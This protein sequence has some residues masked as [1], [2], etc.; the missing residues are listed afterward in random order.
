MRKPKDWGQPCPNPGCAHYRLM[1]RG[2]ISALSTYLTQSGKQG[3]FRCS[4][5][6]TTC[7]ETRD[8]VTIAP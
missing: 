4:A 2:N 1:S 6:P 7:S 8:T 5:C 3:I